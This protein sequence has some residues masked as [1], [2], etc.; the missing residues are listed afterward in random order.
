MRYTQHAKLAY[1]VV[2]FYEAIKRPRHS[3]GN[4]IPSPLLSWRVQSTLSCSILGV[5]VREVI[6]LGTII[7][8][9]SHIQKERSAYTRTAAMHSVITTRTDEVQW[10]AADLQECRSDQS[11]ALCLRFQ[12]G[13]R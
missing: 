7:D 5:A 2:V 4:P 10:G 13:Q 12:S 3:A 8:G 1:T 9:L 6:V 11:L